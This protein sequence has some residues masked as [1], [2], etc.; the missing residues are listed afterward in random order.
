MFRRIQR[1]FLRFAFHHFYNTFAFTYDS[2]SAIV[3]RG[4]WREW[5][6]AAIPHIVG[7]RVLEMPCGTGN[8]LLDLR[9]AGYITIGVDL[10][11][12]M[13]SLTQNKLQ[14][15]GLNAPLFRARAQA[16]PFA[17]GSFDSITM[18]FPPEFVY[19]PKALAEMRRVL[20]GDGRLIWVD[21]GRLLPCDVWSRL[22]NSAL[23]VVDGSAMPISKF[24]CDV[25]APVGFAVSI[26]IVRD[27][28]SQVMVIVATKRG[29]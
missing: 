23:V 21:G 6:C 17:A 8:L 9:A 11:L 15:A 29:P 13:L 10:S 5:T 28:T 14:R 27:E 1:A 22:L 3:S 19:D 24:V 18:T 20:R 12:A 2:V 25:L 26:D 7:K 16:L 4:H